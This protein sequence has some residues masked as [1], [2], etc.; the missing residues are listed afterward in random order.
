MAVVVD[1]SRPDPHYRGDERGKENRFKVDAIEHLVIPGRSNLIPPEPATGCKQKLRRN[2]AG[3]V[4]D[5][6]KVAS[7]LRQA[8]NAKVSEGP[9]PARQSSGAVSQYCGTDIDLPS[10]VGMSG[11]RGPPD[12]AT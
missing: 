11:L 3:Q 7:T 9:P 12:R 1:P 5:C 2:R 8:V 10:R 6:L 4:I